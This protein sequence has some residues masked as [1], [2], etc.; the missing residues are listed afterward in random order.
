MN[1]A[2]RPIISNVD[3]SNIKTF[4]SS[5]EAVFIAYI[6]DEEGHLKSTFTA[7]AKRHADRF[8]FGIASDPKVA[9]TEHMQFPSIV[10]HKSSEGGQEV[11]SGHA[12]LDALEKFLETATAPT[13]GEFTRRNEMKYMKVRALKG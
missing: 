6:P 7:F 1:R 12:G 2:P 5:D 3:K 9:K 10:C 13:I 4:K 8:T 11:F